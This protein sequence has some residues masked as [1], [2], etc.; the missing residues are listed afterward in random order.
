[1][2]QFTLI[3]VFVLNFFLTS[4]AF[5]VLEFNLVNPSLMLDYSSLLN[6]SSQQVHTISLDSANFDSVLSSTS[7]TQDFNDIFSQVNR[8]LILA[9]YP[10][11]GTTLTAS[12]FSSYRSRAELLMKYFIARSDGRFKRAIKPTS[13][14]ILSAAQ[15]GLFK[16]FKRNLIR[17]RIVNNL[18]EV[19][20]DAVI[21]EEEA[22][23]EEITELV[24][25]AFSQNGITGNVFSVEN[26]FSK[27]ID[28]EGKIRC[29]V[30]IAN[31]EKMIV[32]EDY[33]IKTPCHG[34]T[35]D[36]EEDPAL[37][38]AAD[39]EGGSVCDPL[40]WKYFY[41]TLLRKHILNSSTLITKPIN[42]RVSSEKLSAKSFI[43]TI[44]N[45]Y[46]NG[47]IAP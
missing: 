28:E 5:A 4:S 26:A 39:E 15:T 46:S 25:G 18:D 30:N 6:V 14:I 44:V 23:E 36:V 21:S 47:L 33:F 34:L 8:N 19:A 1:M 35:Y 27:T 17:G 2:K 22:P 24:P 42:P 20:R 38:L 16:S 12:A 11:L 32:S 37:E 7:S 43:D 13:P 29:Q 41:L 31:D 3:T 45:P 9:M 10:C 40:K